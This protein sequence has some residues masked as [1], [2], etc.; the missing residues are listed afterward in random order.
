MKQKSMLLLRRARKIHRSAH[1]LGLNL[2]AVME[3]SQLNGSDLSLYERTIGVRNGTS[4]QEWISAAK[5]ACDQSGCEYLGVFSEPAEYIGVEVAKA[6]GLPYVSFEQINNTH[7]KVAMRKQ[8]HQANVDDT[9]SCLVTQPFYENLVRIFNVEQRPLIIKPKDARASTGVS[10]IRCEQDIQHAL[11]WIL[12]SGSYES[13]I[14]EEYLDGPEFSVEAFSLHGEHTVVAITEKQKDPEH[15]VELG[16]TV[17]APLPTQQENQIKAYVVSVLNALGITD[18]PTHTEI[19]LTEQGPRIVETH[20]RNG[21]DEIDTLV[22][23]TTG[24]DLNKLWVKQVS[25]LPLTDDLK[26]LNYQGIA[27]IRYLVPGKTGKVTA[28]Y[29]RESVEKIPGV[30][31]VKTLI[32]EGEQ[33]AS[34]TDSNA[35]A[36]SILAKAE[37]ARDL[38]KIFDQAMAKLEYVIE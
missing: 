9:F 33:I 7:D 12:A 1:E 24:I 17:P 26:N 13:F 25:G 34:L 4:L 6:I 37:S 14:A 3:Q 8:L 15:F 27:G 5:Y 16:H 35:R 20:L 22:K 11:D 31:A 18:G 10:L 32:G 21:G 2:T 30:L 36:L 19:I 23:L 28:I 38:A 29:G